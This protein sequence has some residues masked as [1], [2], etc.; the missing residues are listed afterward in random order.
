MWLLIMPGLLGVTVVRLGLGGCGPRLGGRFGFLSLGMRSW[1]GW[2]ARL[3]MWCWR[4][5]LGGEE[6][7]WEMESQ[8]TSF[9]R[10]GVGG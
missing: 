2:T 5:L 7:C 9:G 1:V 3:V 8:V 4:C 10:L 6:P